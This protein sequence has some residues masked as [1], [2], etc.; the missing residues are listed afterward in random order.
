MKIVF[1]YSYK[2]YF[3]DN[4]KNYATNYYVLVFLISVIF[5]PYNMRRREYMFIYEIY[6][7]ITI[8]Y[9]TLIMIFLGM[10]ISIFHP[11]IY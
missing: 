10:H 7:T 11:K 8:L 9:N 5:F 6:F 1:T 4:T 2:T 3:K